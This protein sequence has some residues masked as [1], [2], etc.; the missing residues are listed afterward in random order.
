[1]GR[2]L[3]ARGVGAE[4]EPSTGPARELGHRGA[5]PQ[6]QGVRAAVL[7]YRGDREVGTL[8]HRG[9]AMSGER[10]CGQGEPRTPRAHEPQ[11]RPRTPSSAPV[12]PA[13]RT[14]LP[15]PQS[16]PVLRWCLTSVLSILPDFFFFF[17]FCSVFQKE[18]PLDPKQWGSSPLRER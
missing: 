1:M 14:L 5:A 16:S 11:E 15:G 6:L 3:R 2:R 13:P 18:A 7:P 4:P 9:S 17:P 12:S 8:P 10:A